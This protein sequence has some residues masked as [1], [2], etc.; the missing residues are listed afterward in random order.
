MII[1]L[2]ELTAMSS[3]IH[4]GA[5]V[6]K[7]AVLCNIR[8]LVLMIGL[9]YSSN[10]AFKTCTDRG[11]IVLAIEINANPFICCLPFVVAVAPQ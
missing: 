6:L 8:V 2:W 9:T 5:E 10:F 3:P 11:I 1:V 7:N 4:C